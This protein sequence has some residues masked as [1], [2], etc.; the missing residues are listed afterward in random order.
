VTKVGLFYGKPANKADIQ[1]KNN[2]D[3][4]Y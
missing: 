2:P 1:L 4:M 3:I